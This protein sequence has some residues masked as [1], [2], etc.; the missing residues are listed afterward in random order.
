MSKIISI[1]TVCYNCKDDLIRTM[2][3]IRGLKNSDIEYIVID[4]NSTDGTQ[5]LIEDYKDVID[6]FISE[7]DSGIYD[8]MN[9]SLNFIKGDYVVYL[10][11]GDLF[12][13]SFP[14]VLDILKR[15]STLKAVWGGHIL[16]YKYK[17]TA[18]PSKSVSDVMELFSNKKLFGMPVCHQSLFIRSDLMKKYKYDTSYKICADYKLF[19]NLLGD[20]SSHEFKSISDPICLFEMGG[21]SDINRSLLFSEYESIYED[22]FNK[23]SIYFE[24]SKLREF[25]YSKLRPLARRFK[26]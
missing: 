2:E 6:C 24:I 18:L 26:L 11:A 14:L 16:D 15:N 10:N 5:V 4:G 13:D 21:M 1:V 23:K 19:L 25:L 20:S 9:K 12:T 7:K 8:A 3:N 17:K 22:Y